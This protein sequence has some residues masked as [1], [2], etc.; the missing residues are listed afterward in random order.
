ML[1]QTLKHC[2]KLKE[3]KWREL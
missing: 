2:S 3:K 1:N